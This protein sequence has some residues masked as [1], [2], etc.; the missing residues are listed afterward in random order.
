M[1][2]LKKLQRQSQEKL[3]S[4]KSK[5]GLV[6]SKLSFKKEPK[7]DK[8][9]SENESISES[10]KKDKEPLIESNIPKKGSKKRNVKVKEEKPKKKRGRPKSSDKEKNSK[11]RSASKSSSKSNSKSRKRK[12][13]QKPKIKKGIDYLKGKYNIRVTEIEEDSN[14]MGEEDIVDNSCCTVCSNRNCIRAAETQNYTLM[15]NCI[16]DREHISTLINP[17]SIAIGNAIEIA[18]ANK[19]KKMIEMIFE[20]LNNDKDPKN[21]LIPR[22]HIAEPKIKLTDTGENSVYMVGVQ[23]RKIN[24]TRGNKMGND[25]FIR[26]DVQTQ[27]YSLV[28]DICRIIMEKCDDP[29]FI[30]FFK[31]L[32]YNSDNSYNNTQYNPMNRGNYMGQRYRSN[33]YNYSN[34]LSLSFESYIINAVLKGNVEM[35]K[36]LLKGMEQ[37]YNYGFN[38]LH[39]QVLGETSADNLSVKVRTSLTKKPQTN[40]GMTPMHVVCINPDVSFIKKMI[41]LGADWNILDDLNRKPIHYAACCKEDGPINYLISLGALI[42]EVDKEKKS[43]LMYAC[44]AGRLDCVKALL[45]KRANILL[46]DKLTK[47]TAFHFACKNGYTDIVKYFLENTDIKIDMPGEDRMT[48][49]MLASLYGH[50]DLVTFLLEN[51]A[52]ITKKDKF[53]RTALLHSIRGGHIKIASYLLTKGAEYEQPDNSNNYPLHYACAAGFKNIVELLLK[54]GA[55]PNPSNDWKYTPLEIGFVKNHFGIIKF[56]LNYVDV[57][58]KFNLDM[59]L[60]HYSFKKITKKVVEEE[61][62]YL[63]LEKKC[64]INVQ[65]FYGDS[66]MHYL[67]LFNFSKFR[68]DNNDYINE[69]NKYYKNLSY[70]ERD[71]KAEEE[72]K[73]LMK[74][75]FE[76]LKQCKDLDINLVNKEGKTPFQLAIENNNFYFLEEILKLNPQLCFVDQKGNSVFHSLIPF[77]YEQ[78]IPQDKKLYVI[79][80]ILDRLKDTLSDDELNRISNSYDEKGFT[81]LLKLMYEYSQ[82]IGNIF[83]NIKQEET[84]NYKK[85]KALQPQNQ[86]INMKEYNDEENEG[87]E[88][89][90]EINNNNNNMFNNN[91]NMF[92]NNNFNPF[93]NN[94]NFNP[95]LN[96][97]QN[98]QNNQDIENKISQINLS[99][100]ELNEVHAISL[101][102]LQVFIDFLFTIIKK[103]ILLK[104]NPQIKVGKLSAF[105]KSPTNTEDRK[106]VNDKE[107][108]KFSKNTRIELQYLS[109]QGKNSILLYLM[110]YPSKILLKYFMDELNIPINIYNLYKRNAL[111]FLFDNI[112]KIKEIES[113]NKMTLDTLNYLIEKGIDINQIDYLGN[114]P[115]FYLAKNNFNID[116]LN[117]LYN[118]KCDINKFNKDDENSLFY[119]IRK[120]DFEKVQTLIETFK[121]DYTL[122]DSKK[123]TIMHYLCNDEISSTDMDERLCDYLLTKRVHLNTEDIL[124]RTPIHYLFVKIN[125]EYN[126]QDIDPVNTLTKFLEYDEVDPE[127]KD[128]YGNTPLHYACQRGS[129]ISTISL[130][131]KKVDYD[132]KNKENN[133]PLAYSLLFKKENVAISLI[134]QNVDLDQYAYALED[135]NEKKKIEEINKNKSRNS[136]VSILANKIDENIKKS[137]VDLDSSIELESEDNSV[138][139][140]GVKNEKSRVQQ[141]KLTSNKK[142]NIK[143]NNI[144]NINE[145]MEGK[146]EELLEKQNEELKNNKSNDNNKTNLDN[147]NNSDNDNND[148]EDDDYNSEDD[149]NS[150]NQPQN[151]YINIRNNNNLINRFSRRNNVFGRLNN[152][153]PFAGN[154]NYI[155]NNNNTNIPKINQNVCPS[156]ITQFFSGDKKGIKLFRVCIKNNFQ[157]LT[158]LFITR[159]YG[160]MK[161]VEDA[162]FEGKFNLAMKLLIR[163]PNNA[164]YQSLNNEGQNLFHILGH[165]KNIN[166]TDLPKFLD[167]LYSKQIP[168]DTKDNYG[169]TPLHYAAKNIFEQ[170]INFILNKYKNNK[171][172]LDIKNNDNF[173]PLILAMKGNNILNINKNIFDLLFTNKDINQ[174]YP[175]D[176]SLLDKNLKS[177]NNK[178]NQ[179]RCSLLLYIVRNLLKQSSQG[180]PSEQHLNLK[181]YYKKL[182]QNGASITQKDSKG[183]TCLN[184]AVLENNLPFLKMLCT[185]SGNNIDKN[186]V[187]INGK[188]LIHYCVSLNDFGSYENEEMLKYLLDNNFLSNNRD[189]N[190]KTPLDYALEQKSMKNLTILK[191]KRIPG[192][193]NIQLNKDNYINNQDKLDEEKANLIPIMN[194]EKDSEEYYNKMLETAPPS[195]RIKKPNLD[196]YKSE[197]FELYKENDEYWD[198]S[199]T[200]V[201]LQ[202]GIYGEYMFYFIQLVHDLGKDMYIV[203]TQFG[204]IGEEGAN[205]RSPFNTLDEAKNEFGKIFKSKTGNAWEERNNFERIKGKYMLLSYNKVQ[206]KPNELLK[207]FDYKKCPKSNLDNT[208]IHSL[209]KAFT[210]SSIIEKAFK[211]SGV[212][213]EFFNYSMLNKETLLKARGYLIELYQKVQELENIR[214]I[215]PNTLIQNNSNNDENE[216]KSED[217]SEDNGMDLDENDSKKGKKSKGKGRK[218]EKSSSNGEIK[219]LKDKTEA[220]ISKTNEIMALSSRYYELIPKEKY[221]N[222]CILPFDRLDDVKNEIQIIDNLTYVEKAVNILL[223]A[224]NKINSINPLDYIYNSLQTYFE[225]L[226]NDSPEFMTIEKYIN[227]TSSFDKVINIFRVTRKG[228]TER[229]NKF[230]DLP[231]HY[232]LFHGTKIFNLIG[233]F[234]NGLKIAPPEAPMTGYMFGKGIYLAD[235]YQKSINYCDTIQDK[236]NP[237]K[238]KTY[239]FILLCEAALGRMYEPKR[240]EKLDLEKLPF[241]NQGY[242]SLKSVSSSGPDPN[243][244]F[245]CNNGITI[246]L[247]NIVS[248]NSN[249]IEYST[250]HPEYI[251]YDTAQV[252][253]RYIVKMERD[254]NYL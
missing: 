195:K 236:S 71:A 38:A 253:I 20:S 138:F 239:S 119:Y 172:I 5:D 55:S 53:K 48:G 197:F 73:I 90:D 241:L 62:K 126:S 234:S 9:K 79:N 237:K 46:K 12:K 24:Q 8:D 56:L 153:N 22:C 238:I 54:A 230:K 102:K 39:Y 114:N 111:Y 44:M 141:I 161:A 249:A 225:L 201:N 187:D 180:K 11:S 140:F 15:K 23:T 58:T 132:I 122:S 43:P 4:S 254:S 146:E 217:L 220:I 120:K 171:Y 160:L 204:R 96:N 147:E 222:S 164:I 221:K 151:N 203:T 144:E 32:K 181:Y 82:K 124:G 235:M 74:K 115:F 101:S 224:N 176:E 166:N 206:L 247:G 244:N 19:D 97:N 167:I 198:A 177:D 205:Q 178:N 85:K 109:G 41:E 231:N 169:N 152:F 226:K 137:K 229:I 81:P 37:N 118:N 215:K 136:L 179:Y 150:Y 154:N 210:D 70:K 191:N 116:L 127:H 219:T 29:S 196:D 31:S 149:D 148:E 7:K 227:N 17:Y 36:H 128:I 84:Y 117:I 199:L 252:K 129:I 135:R 75:I 246:P 182:I 98:N 34:N 185:D 213:R 13:S 83:N 186:L 242:N 121:V 134:Q 130:G 99:K 228:E 61:M 52:K 212:D 125:D 133:S 88:E 95:F 68:T 158:H 1:N 14:L 45:R 103:Y 250:A 174:L 91:N 65:D 51:K 6:Q 49:L 163:S 139:Q 86:D 77:I 243:K 209:L 30:D 131:S 59:C 16:K 157:G 216:E 143:K 87:E 240:N 184:Y 69:L 80:E 21:E 110:T 194:F 33:Y 76:I 211:D 208:E 78:K 47:N 142:T 218:K 108:K 92:N 25:A 28:N 107:V 72:Y 93:L 189:N 159:G 2:K 40:F 67:A 170:F 50:Y 64:D 3:L 183:R 190:N 63:M 27:E 173:T 223:G 155:R 251:A 232:L 145:E 156:F 192:T 248:Y 200:K 35:A 106:D 26:D 202:N 112:N 89:E 123:R 100:N 233:I 193:E 214:Q 162:F 188:S 94:S 66:C 10:N 168:L 104:M 245:I 18:I 113:N 207:P 165:I 42:D 105:R 175:E 57:N 60:I